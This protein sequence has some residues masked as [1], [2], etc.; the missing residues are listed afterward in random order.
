[1]QPEGHDHAPG[2]K[3]EAECDRFQEYEINVPEVQQTRHCTAALDTSIYSYGVQ[4]IVTSSSVSHYHEAIAP[5]LPR[6]T[7][8]FFGHLEAWVSKEVKH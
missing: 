4:C 6:A 5:S 1:M 2:A 8:Y 7:R 3:I